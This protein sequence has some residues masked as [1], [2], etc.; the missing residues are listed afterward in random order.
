MALDGPLPV[1]KWLLKK[2][3]KKPYK[4]ENS[5]NQPTYRGYISS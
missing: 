5:G 1:C 4:F 3:F 2:P